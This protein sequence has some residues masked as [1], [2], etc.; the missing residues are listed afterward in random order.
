VSRRGELIDLNNRHAATTDKRLALLKSQAQEKFVHGVG[1]VE[2]PVMFVGE[3][4][5]ASEHRTGRPFSGASGR[6]LDEMLASVDLA[7]EQVYITNVV[8]WRPRSNRTPD[9]HEI[10][11]SLPF[12]LEEIRIVHPTLLVTLGKTALEALVHRKANIGQWHGNTVSVID[13]LP[14]VLALYHPAVALYQRANRPTLFADFQ[15]I[16]VFLRESRWRADG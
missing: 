5:G 7:R 6:L 9:T 14:K 8:H 12:L 1:P 4:P 3:A 15:K 13:I 16:D 10:E 2:P 11:A